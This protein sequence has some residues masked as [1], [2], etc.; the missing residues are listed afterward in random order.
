MEDSRRLFFSRIFGP[1]EACPDKFE[2]LSAD[3]LKRCGGLPLAI[4]SIASLLADQSTRTWH[5]VKNSLGSMFEGNPT[6]EDMKQIL[7]LSYRNLPHHLKSCLLYLGMYPEDSTVE[8]NDL[9]RQWM[10]EGFVRNTHGVDAE[11]VGGSYFNE[12][13]NRSM[14]QPVD[15]DYNN[16]EVLSCRVHDLMLDLIRFKSVEEG[17]F[18]AITDVKSTT[19]MHKKIR[20]LS[21]HYGGTG[22]GVV[23]ATVTGSLSQV[24]SVVA[25][26]SVLMPSFLGFKYV[27]VLLLEFRTNWVKID[28]SSQR[29]REIDLAGV[30]E[31]NL[32]RYLKIVCNNT[33]M[34]LPNQLWRLEYLETVILQPLRRL[35]IPSDVVL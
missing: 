16:D 17:F 1:G 11:D 29:R 12:L 6:L 35:F 22:H 26:T 27:R 18:D 2:E 20:R 3:I 30:C 21:L 5:Y 34:E 13:I 4:I 31:L 33:G 9:V 10:A 8:K 7:D 28:S 19:G 25:F 15:T 23:P 32:L 24:R 14:I